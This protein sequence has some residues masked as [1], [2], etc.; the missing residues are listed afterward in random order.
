MALT[1]VGR[2]K[3]CAAIGGLLPSTTCRHAQARPARC[4]RPSAFIH[5]SLSL[6]PAR[7]QRL[8]TLAL[9]LPQA[10]PTHAS[11]SFLPSSWVPPHPG[12][13]PLRPPQ[14]LPRLPVRYIAC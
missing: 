4:E 10:S 3:C 5:V 12:P 1:G 13:L 14:L 8:P 6:A 11:P 7:T 2:E 9:T